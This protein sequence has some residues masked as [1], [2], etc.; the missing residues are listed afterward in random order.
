MR[1]R[2]KP[3]VIE[4]FQWTGGLDQTEE[5]L[6]IVE[7]IQT[8]KVIIVRDVLQIETLEGVMEAK[9]GDWIIRGVQGEIY[10]CKPDIFEKTYEE[11]SQQLTHPRYDE[12]SLT[13][14]S[15]RNLIKLR[16]L[17]K[18]QIRLINKTISQR[19]K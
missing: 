12:E 9:S 1:Y 16:D 11:A 7:A 8:G 18:S 3:V 5:P 13:H 15:K 14:Y 2:K 6:W 19:H 4:A 10:P 17:M